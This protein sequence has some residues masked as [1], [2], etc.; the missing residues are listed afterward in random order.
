MR[1]CGNVCLKMAALVCLL[2]SMLTMAFFFVPQAHAIDY[3]VATSGSDGNS[4]ARSSPFRTI[5]HAADVVNPGDIVHVSAGTYAEAVEIKRNGTSSNRIRFISDSQWG[6]TVTGDGS[7]NDSFMIREANYIDIVGFEVTNKTG[8]QGIELYGSYGRALGNHVHN[9]WAHGCTDWLGGAGINS[10]NYHGTGNEIIGNLVHDIGD[11]AHG[12][13]SVHGIYVAN[14]H[15][16]VQNNI[17]Y[18]NQGWGITSW[19]YA[20]HNTIVNNTVFNND[21]A[22]INTGASDGGV[23]DK[24]SEVGNN[25]VVNNGTATNWVCYP[26]GNWSPA[27]SDPR[28]GIGQ[29]G[30]NGSTNI[31]IN[32]IVYGNNPAD[33]HVQKGKVAQTITAS[34]SSVFMNYTG[35]GTGDYHLKSNSPA[36]NAGSNQKAPAKDFA[37]GNRPVGGAFDIGGYEYGAAAGNWPWY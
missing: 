26:S 5:Q 36:V 15:N 1:I 28:Y 6:A 24:Y 20:T 2:E 29:E 35:D 7:V 37:G 21:V 23:V 9:V 25:I 19:H 33:I 14:A 27:C 17:S 8:Y 34:P 3:Y 22:G 18:R 13:A 11:F 32:N 31:Y 30:S 16:V 4:G 10:S 12:C